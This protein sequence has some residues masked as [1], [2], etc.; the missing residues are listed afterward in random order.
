MQVVVASCELVGKGS[1]HISRVS[2]TR[3]SSAREEEGC[4][5]IA[6]LLGFGAN[7]AGDCGLARPGGAV[8]PED[9]REVGVIDPLHNFVDDCD[10]CTLE[11]QE[12]F[13][14][15][16]QGLY[17]RIELGFRCATK[18]VKGDGVFSPPTILARLALMVLNTLD[19]H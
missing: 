10:T 17:I 7:R 5:D 12:E 19:H 13:P 18:L 3:S 2:L 8:E 6:C 14:V 4:S 9:R 15:L 1:E 11:A 16:I